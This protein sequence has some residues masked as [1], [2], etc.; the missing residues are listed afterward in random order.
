MITLPPP[1]VS[2]GRYNQFIVNR[3]GVPFYDY[4]SP[5]QQI[6]FDDAVVAAYRYGPGH[7]VSFVLTHNDPFYLLDIDDCLI[8][9][10]WTS[11]A[12]DLMTRLQ[13]AAVEV[14]RS[15]G[16]LHIIGTCTPFDHSC[17][18]YN[19]PDT[20]LE[21]YTHSKAI[22]LTG[23][24]VI[25]NVDHDS[26]G[27]LIP[28][29]AVM[30]PPR[31]IGNGDEWT[32]GPCVD[33]SG[34]ADD[35]E[36][37][38]VAVKSGSAT[39]EIFGGGRASFADL[40]DR[41]VGRLSECYPTTNDKSDYGESEVDAALCQHLMFWT[42]KDCDRVKR[43][44]LRSSLARLKWTDNAG[45]LDRT[46]LR[47]LGLQTDV[48]QRT[49][50]TT[51]VEDTILEGVVESKHV[52]TVV[53]GFQYLAIDQQLEYFHGCCY[54]IGNH[55]AFTP[56]GQLLKPEQF[57]ARYGGY[58]FALD[59]SNDSTT[60][61]AWEVL[62]ESQGIRF[63][64]VHTT[65]FRPEHP[66]GAIIDDDGIIMVNTYVPIETR[67]VR[68]DTSPFDDFL[69]K[70]LPVQGDRDI[71]L[72]YMAS[73]VQNPGSKFQWWPVIQ[74]TEGNGKTLLTWVLKFCV[75]ARYT[76]MPAAADISNT[77][78]A[79]M[80][81]KLLIGIEEFCVGDRREVLEILKP[82]VTN[83]SIDI[84]GKG[85]NQ[86]M[87]DNRANG[88]LN[89]NYVGGMPITV[90]TRRYCVFHTAQQSAGDL[91]RDKMDGDYFPALYDWLND[92]GFAIVNNMLREYAI[93]DHLNPATKCKRAPKTSTT[94]AAVTASL[95]AIEQ[96]IL[97]HVATDHVGF[98]GGWIS[99][100]AVDRLLERM[101]RR[102]PHIKRP[103]LLKSI[104]YIPHPGLKNGRPSTSIPL[105]GGKP[106]LYVLTDHKSI[107]TIDETQ[108]I[109]DYVSAQQTADLMGQL[110]Q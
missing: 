108:I 109:S 46:I 103:A 79:W 90:D 60:R 16:G 11:T 47:A 7:G 78:N 50:T 91:V 99:S 87:G 64:K 22:A 2:L 88:I 24:N 37:I 32:S 6:S 96:E 30:F 3:D 83:A 9:G 58:V 104:G 107:S 105:D 89:T 97:E 54:V 40:W 17:R 95:G 52:P 43:L 36:L 42:G 20:E 27:V 5:T 18:N 66:P 56:D 63:P 41:N 39:R 12:I 71:I 8:D 76:H 51:G 45:Y 77:F 34:I 81:G 73:L 72:S 44:M 55:K 15:G 106:I 70:L 4:T 102:V 10:A 98:C 84:Q 31:D 61:N 14:S 69:A 75:G 57:K 33:W 85:D 86:V 21:L 74:G 93:P 59:S 35:D 92:D 13:G 48:H 62:T 67:R 80:Y 65:C 23:T 49:V 25:G 94:L 82:Y 29:S 19:Y 110:M 38:R 53:A 26:S 28:L 68:G 100:M 101:R 1:L